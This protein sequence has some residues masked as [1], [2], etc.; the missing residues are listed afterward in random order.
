MTGEPVPVRK[1]EWVEG[2]E[3]GRPGGDD[4]PF[5]FSGSMIVQGNGIARVTATASKTE[6]GKIGK[7]LSE[8]KEEPTRLKREMGTLVKEA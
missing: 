8:V 7:A 6:L 1:S 3:L 5:V 2:P 4:L